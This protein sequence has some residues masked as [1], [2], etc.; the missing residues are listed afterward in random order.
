MPIQF[1]NSASTGNITLKSAT[2]GSWSYVLPNTSG[3]ANQFLGTDGSGNFQWVTAGITTTGATFALT[4]TTP[5]AF[6]NA[7]ISHHTE[8]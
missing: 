3:S 5:N 4:T 7:S 6:T 8:R 1:D 2:S